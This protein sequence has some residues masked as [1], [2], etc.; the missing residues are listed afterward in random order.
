MSEIEKIIRLAL[1][2]LGIK[3]DTLGYNLIT[4]ATVKVIENPKLTSN[5]TQLFTLVSKEV[6]TL[7]PFRIEANILN[8][9]TY[10]FRK[11]GLVTFNELFG[12]EIM[13]GDYK[14]STAEFLRLLAEYY[15]LGLYK[16]YKQSV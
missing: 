4:L 13:K 12:M 15:N 2:R 16:Q 3:C 11:N 1:I 5:Q 8:A 14:P 9:I 7:T 10:T 6:K